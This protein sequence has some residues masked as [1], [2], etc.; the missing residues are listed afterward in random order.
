MSKAQT[1]TPPPPVE[2][3]LGLAR[4]SAALDVV[5]CHALGAY[6]MGQ[7]AP[8]DSI[9]R[10]FHTTAMALARMRGDDSCPAGTTQVDSMCV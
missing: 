6:K 5:K 2:I 8:V 3:L 4:I 10:E 7:G 1:P 9:L